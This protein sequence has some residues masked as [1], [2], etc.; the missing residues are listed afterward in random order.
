MMDDRLRDA[1]QGGMDHVRNQI[2]G[3]VEERGAPA[4]AAPVDALLS[5]S[6][7][8][9]GGW[10]GRLVLHT[11]E[12][13]C[14]KLVSLLFAGLP[15]DAETVRDAACELL[16]MIA[17]STRTL[18]SQEHLE[19]SVGAPRLEPAP[20]ALPLDVGGAVQRSYLD[21]PVLIQLKEG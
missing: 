16:N 14:A 17:E 7:A 10:S 19:F 9:A 13:L 4:R 1:L 2:A 8:V 18:L 11:N 15:I 5:S 6:L 12:A 20:S 21:E 3:M